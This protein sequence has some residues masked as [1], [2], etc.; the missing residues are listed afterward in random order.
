MLACWNLQLAGTGGEI[1]IPKTGQSAEQVA[2]RE[3]FLQLRTYLLLQKTLNS[4]LAASG[5]I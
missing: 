2:F 3:A 1:I 5:T 4:S